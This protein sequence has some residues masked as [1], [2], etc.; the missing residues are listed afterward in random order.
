MTKNTAWFVPCFLAGWCA[1]GVAQPVAYWRHEEGAPGALIPAGADT[2]LDS[3]GNGNHMQTFNPAF[4]S[5]TYSSTV[6]PVP[7]RSGLPNTRSLDF[8]PGGDDPGLNDDNFTSG[9]PINA[10]LFNAVT[11]EVA[12]RMDTVAGYQAIL[13]K[14]GKPLGDMPGEDNSPVPPFKVLIRGD[15]FPGGVPNQLFVEWIDGDGTLNSDIHFL[16]SHQTVVPN[17]W[18]HVAVTIN[19]T[20][21]ALYVAR[22]TGPYQ[23]LDSISGDFAGPTGEVIVSEPLGWTIG[24]GMF[25]NGV[26]DWSDALIDEAR[27]SNGALAPSQFLFNAIPEPCSVALLLIGVAACRWRTTTRRGV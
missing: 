23:L 19:G 2:V 16:A 20:D 1:V 8:G 3:S 17:Q 9:K 22:E 13:G 24:R 11:V 18:Y 7:L 21:A 6:S 10:Q 4:T 27:I 15:D 14:D 26:T 5:A 12:F 25:N